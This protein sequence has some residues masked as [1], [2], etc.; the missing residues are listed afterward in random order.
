MLTSSPFGLAVASAA[1]FLPAR[2]DS[3]AEPGRSSLNRCAITAPAAL[4]GVMPADGAPVPPDL[5]I[6]FT[7]DRAV[8]GSLEPGPRR[9]LFRLSGRAVGGRD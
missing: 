6:S 1:A 2:A 8:A 4:K 7:F 9:S 3:P 5:G